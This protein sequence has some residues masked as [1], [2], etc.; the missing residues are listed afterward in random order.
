MSTLPGLHLLTLF[1]VSPPCLPMAYLRYIHTL[2]CQGCRDSAL[3]LRA[4]DLFML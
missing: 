4:D 3:R 2:G 1:R